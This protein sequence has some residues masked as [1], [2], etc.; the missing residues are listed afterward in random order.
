[1]MD[2]RRLADT[3]TGG[4]STTAK[5]EIDGAFRTTGLVP[6]LLTLSAC[7]LA[8][9]GAAES[10]A[11]TTMMDERRLADTTTGGATPTAKTEMDGAPRTMI[12]GS[13]ALLL[14]AVLGLGVRR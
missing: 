5:T 10:D 1:M 13:P 7:L 2:E 4:A 9:Q 3:T 12:A 6:L 11:T 14:A 8:G